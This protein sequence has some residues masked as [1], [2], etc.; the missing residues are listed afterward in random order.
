MAYQEVTGNALVRII[1]LVRDIPEMYLQL[2]LKPSDRWVQRFLWRDMIT[3][4]PSK[5]YEFTLVLFGVNASG[6][7]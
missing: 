6:A 1:V 7:A 4:A 2:H 3:N 5:I